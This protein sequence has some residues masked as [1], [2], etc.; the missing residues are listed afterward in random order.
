ML[1]SLVRSVPVEDVDD[2]HAY[3]YDHEVDNAV[4]RRQAVHEYELLAESEIGQRILKLR[5]DEDNLLGTV[6]LATSP[7]LIKELWSKVAELLGG[8]QTQ[9]QRVALAIVP[10]EE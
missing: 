10:A 4:S 8:N 7:K 6:W 3:R 9:L 1:L 5:E 2:Y